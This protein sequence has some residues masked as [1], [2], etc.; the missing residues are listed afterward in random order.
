ME[1]KEPDHRYTQQPSNYSHDNNDGGLVDG[2][3]W[4][5]D[6]EDDHVDDT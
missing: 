4:F 2:I 5:G 6:G 1:N 3:L